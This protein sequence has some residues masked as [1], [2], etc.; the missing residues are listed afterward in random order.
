[1]RER[2]RGRESESE[3]EREIKRK[4]EKGGGGGGGRRYVGRR[5]GVLG[6]RGSAG[7]VT[8]A[9]G[10]VLSEKLVD[11]RPRHRVEVAS[12]ERERGA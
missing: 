12:C 9:K 7:D 10:G 5:E 8:R 3:R 1:V 4:K 6:V 2:E 11:I